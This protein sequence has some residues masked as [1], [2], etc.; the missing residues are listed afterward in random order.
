MMSIKVC[1]VLTANTCIIQQQI[2]QQIKGVF[3]KVKLDGS[4]PKALK[5]ISKV[6]RVAD[7]DGKFY[8]TSSGKLNELNPDDD[9]ITALD[10]VA[11]YKEDFVAM[12]K[13]IY[14]EGTRVLTM[15]FYDPNFHGYDWKSLIKKYKPLALKASTD[16]DYIFVFNLLLGQLNASHM[17]YRAKTSDRT[18]NDN[19][20]LLG[21]E[22]KNISNGVQVEYVLK[23]SPANKSKVDLKVRDIITAV[24]DKPKSKNTNFIVY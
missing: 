10:H 8:F 18:N 19:I 21:V 16:Q 6:E 3:F 2:P 5:G 11:K 24:N 14:Q 13:Q 9:E 17:G 7:I 1:L 20:G 23:N 22:V 4:S 12:N 15:G